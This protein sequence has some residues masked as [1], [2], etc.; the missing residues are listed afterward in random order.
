M[1]LLKN[2]PA[3]LILLLLL[4]GTLCTAS[5]IPF[6]SVYIVEVLG[7]DPLYITFY[8]MP[9]LAMTL[10][11][12]RVLGERIDQ[13]HLIAPMLRILVAAFG[14]G[15]VT[16]LVLHSYLALIIIC[17]PCFALSNGAVSTM[18][19]FGRLTAEQNNWDIARYNSCLR[20]TTS[21]GWMLAP[22]ATFMIAG[23]FGAQAVLYAALGLAAI[24][25]VSLWRI[26]P[27][28]FA[29]QAV[30]ITTPPAQSGD[31]NA[32]NAIW[33]AAGVCLLFSL[34]HSSTSTS[35]P[36]FYIRE[37]GLPSF[38][39]GLSFSVKTLVEIVAILL[40]PWIMAKLGAKRALVCAAIMAICAFTV[41][42]N[43]HNLP[44]LI[45]GAALE[46]LYYGVFAAVG[47]Y[48]V[49]SLAQGRMGR[50]TSLYM[51]SLFLGGLIASPVMGLVAQFASFRTVI[52]LAS[53]WVIAALLIL[54]MTRNATKQIT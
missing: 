42:A 4:S 40:T 47:L 36:L 19:S 23:A 18:Y 11:V 46:G 41:L 44:Q 3:V 39:V 28:N 10:V 7:K 31:K 2:R 14:V 52:Q 22:A 53:F 30:A 16:M 9:T 54:I 15:L 48:Y 1:H 51:N 34:A 8:A 5:L 43:V 45:A 17:A 12:N 20:A 33:I 13:G 27:T 26:I 35:L 6:M 21:L 25:A 49:Q 38:A 29:K 32:P 50:A 24:W 37:V